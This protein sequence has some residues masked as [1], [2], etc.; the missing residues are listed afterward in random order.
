MV[1]HV[2]HA[3]PG[4][5]HTDCAVTVT[6]GDF[7]QLPPASVSVPLLNSSHRLPM[8][9]PA[10]PHALL[11]GICYH[12]VQVS[13]ETNLVTEIK[14]LARRLQ[15]EAYKLARDKKINRL[16]SSLHSQQKLTLQ[17]IGKLHVIHSKTEWKFVQSSGWIAGCLRVAE[18]VLIEWRILFMHDNVIY[19]Y[20]RLFPYSCISFPCSYTSYTFH[21]FP[22]N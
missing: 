8:V 16:R 4:C 13:R 9:T 6:S 2:S 1:L 15:D 11:R 19:K 7:T 14:V 21:L 5:V 12:L 20:N 3:R 18:C 17:S 22:V 10:L